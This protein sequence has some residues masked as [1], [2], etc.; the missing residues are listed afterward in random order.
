D[1]KLN[2]AAGDADAIGES[3]QKQQGPVFGKVEAKI[4]KDRQATRQGIEQGLAWLAGK[5]T[6]RD[7]G[8]VSFSGHGDRDERGNFYLIPGDVNARDLAGSCVSGEVLK[9]RLAAMPGRL[10]L[11]LDACHSGA[12]GA[13]QR[14]Q[15]LTDDLVRDLISEEYGVVVLSSSRG[16]EY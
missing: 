8:L 9:K 15:G 3:F 5:M 7:V 10:V 1:L 12:A 2:Y 6:S 11:L 16:D 13:A 14:R 4:V